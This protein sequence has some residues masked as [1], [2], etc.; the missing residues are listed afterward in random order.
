M[1]SRKFESKE[2]LVAY[3][4]QN[5]LTCLSESFAKWEQLLSPKEYLLVEVRTSDG[6]RPAMLLPNA[7][8][9]AAWEADP[10]RKALVVNRNRVRKA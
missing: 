8:L 4:K 3:A 9:K 1:H 5:G 2:A 6:M 10:L 7:T